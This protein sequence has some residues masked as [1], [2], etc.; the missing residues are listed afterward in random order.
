M[1]DQLR[2]IEQDPGQVRGPTE[3]V[4]NGRLTRRTFIKGVDR[5]TVISDASDR[6]SVPGPL[7]MSLAMARNHVT[8][9][10]PSPC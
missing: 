9:Q 3:T 8:C 6:G 2:S 4:E 7:G 1:G 5:I 10:P